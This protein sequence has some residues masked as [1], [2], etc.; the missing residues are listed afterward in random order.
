[1]KIKFDK[2]NIKNQMTND[3]IKKQISQI[4]HN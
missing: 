2:K 1:M 3:K 4:H